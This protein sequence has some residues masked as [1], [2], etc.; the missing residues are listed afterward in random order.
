MGQ[1]IHILF[2]AYLR[3][4]QDERSVGGVQTYI[5][6][7]SET[8]KKIGI[9]P[10]IYQESQKPFETVYHGTKVIGV[11]CTRHDFTRKAIKLVPKHEVVIFGSE[12]LAVKYDGLAI[13]IQHGIY[14]DKP[15]ATIVKS[16]DVWNKARRASILLKKL[17]LVS[18]VVCVD[19]NFINWYRT[20]VSTPN[21]H[22][23][24]IPNF[25]FVPP[26]FEK[27]QDPVRII[28]A[29][30]FVDFRGTRVFG[31]SIVE[32]LKRYNSIKVIIAGEGPDE[33]WL[34]SL[35]SNYPNVG[36]MK[37]DSSQSIEVHKNINIAVVP[38]IGSEG[39][40]LSLL[41][42]MAAQCAVICS[43]V[44]GM[45]NIVIDGHNGVLVPANDIDSLTNAI[46]L[47]IVNPEYR[48]R[49]AMNGYQTV[50]DSF[51][52]DIWEKKWVN[53]LNK[54]IRKSELF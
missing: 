9:E 47:L 33:E 36:F 32:L 10:I 6:N 34:R 26:V 17:N 50:K 29:R 54:Y 30:R 41:E 28:F 8:I 46:E 12:E 39:T 5:Y 19:C 48:N 14:W 53:V 40:S 11:E 43:D 35:L 49:I 37:Y 1:R 31:K 2:Y 52:H 18:E 15:E 20:Q 22:L 51:S 45:T 3:D 44:G 27:Q 42:A 23:A 38:T 4:G 25:S 24:Y 21:V 13:S 7:L 16:L